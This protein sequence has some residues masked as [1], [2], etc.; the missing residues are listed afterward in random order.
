MPK[1]IHA[2]PVRRG[3]HAPRS[4]K[5]PWHGRHGLRTRGTRSL[6]RL[7]CSANE[8]HDGRQRSATLRTA[9]R[10]SMR[11]SVALIEAEAAIGQKLRGDQF[12]S[13]PGRI[14]AYKPPLCEVVHIRGGLREFFYLSRGALRPRCGTCRMLARN[15][16]AGQA[17]DARKP[18]ARSTVG[19]GTLQP[20]ACRRRSAWPPSN[21][22]SGVD[23]HVRRRSTICR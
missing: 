6:K 14:V 16:R 7:R 22:F 19:S 11:S 4:K 17:M 18:L 23:R 12:P 1:R 20:R 9:S 10:P 5:S 15:R 3:S 13:H 2:G 21:C 8:R